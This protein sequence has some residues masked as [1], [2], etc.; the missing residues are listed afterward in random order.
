MIGI[1]VFDREN[2]IESS[3]KQVDQDRI[4]VFTPPVVQTAT[5]FSMGRACL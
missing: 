5:T 4:E 1:V 2:F 3:E